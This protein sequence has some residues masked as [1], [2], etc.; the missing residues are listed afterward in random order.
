M[1]VFKHV[2]SPVQGTLRVDTEGL[3][4]DASLL[5]PT[6]APPPTPLATPSAKYFHHSPFADLHLTNP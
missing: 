5:S 3:S 2:V 1:Y 6:A 4:T